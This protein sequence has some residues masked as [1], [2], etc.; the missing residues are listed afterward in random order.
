MCGLVVK[1][2]KNPFMIK[3]FSL[4]GQ[5]RFCFKKI[6]VLKQNPF[7]YTII[8][9]KKKKKIFQKKKKKKKKE[10][11]KKPLKHWKNLEKPLKQCIQLQNNAH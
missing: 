1:N 2:E 4:I 11:K 8:S 3:T 5:T 6:S 7:L 10:K 9:K